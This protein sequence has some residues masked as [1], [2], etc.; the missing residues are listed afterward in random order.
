MKNVRLITSILINIL[1]PTTPERKEGLN[2]AIASVK[3]SNCSQELNIVVDLN[4]Y[5]GY[6]K[7]VLRMLDK[8]EGLCMVVTDD[9]EV[10]PS[11]IQA[12]YSAYTEAFPNND[13]LCVY[14]DEHW[15]L[16]AFG[17]PF[18]H[19]KTLKEIINPDYFHNFHD[20]E[21]CE[22]MKGR[23]K[24]LPVSHAQVSHYHYQWYPKLER[25]KTYQIG[26]MTSEKDGAIYNMRRVKNFNR[27]TA[28]LITTDKEYP[29]EIDTSWFD[30]VLIKTESPS[31]YERYLLA[32]KSKNDIIYVQDDDCTLDY[33]ALWQN[34][35]GQLTNGITRV[36]YN[37]Y[38]HTGVTLVGWGCF[39]PKTML[40][41]LDKYKDKYGVDKHLLREAD[42]I[43]TYFNK[44]FNTIVMP[45][46]DFKHQ[47]SGRMWNEGHHWSS[48]KEAIDKCILI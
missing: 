42:R 25:D 11:S 27:I 17:L 31:V 32:E 47:K 38:R 13:G 5:E 9:I 46:G 40:K 6:V 43:F 39:F 22:I 29:K 33:K 35:N 20:K 14:G 28:V 24:Y 2:R 23:N 36:H 44:P 12:L 48:M 26:E 37:S 16:K 8:V 19:S 21:M 1:I 45:H 3:R 4:E 34:Y 18:A 30:E 41:N 7:S 10:W 15:D